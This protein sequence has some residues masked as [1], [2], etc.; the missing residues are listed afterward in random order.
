MCHAVSGTACHGKCLNGRLWIGPRS[1]KR[2]ANHGFRFS[3]SDCLRNQTSR[4]FRFT[5]SVT[6]MYNGRGLWHFRIAETE[7]LSTLFHQRC[8]FNYRFANESDLNLSS[9]F[10]RHFTISSDLTS[11]QSDI[12]LHF[13]R[14]GSVLESLIFHAKYTLIAC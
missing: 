10:P 9:P 5:S 12:S 3:K 8:I 11:N 6:C 1:A 14:R 4:F 7:K 13:R 2:T